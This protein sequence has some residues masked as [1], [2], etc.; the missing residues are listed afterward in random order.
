MLNN[1]EQ[2]L[3]KE[4][5]YSEHTCRAYIKDIEQFF[6]FAQIV[7]ENSSDLKEVNQ[8]LARSWVVFLLKNKVTPKSV[9]RKLSSN[10]MFYKFLMTHEL[11]VNNPFSSVQGPKVAKRL[12]EFV[13]KKE[14]TAEKMDHL[15]SG[16]AFGFRDR[17]LFEILYQTGIR[18]SEL[19]NLKE[20]DF[21][22]LSIR[23]VGKRN[24]E[25]VVA[26]GHGLQN[27]LNAL[28]ALKDDLGCNHDY[29]FFTDSLKKMYPKFVYRKI[30]YYLSQV[31][32]MNQKSPHIMRHTFATHLL[33]EGVSIEVLKEILGH[34]NLA[35]TQVYT[36]N[37]FE[38]INS[39]YKSAHPRGHK[40]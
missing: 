16:D 10:R 36:H 40:N 12:P 25:R 23:V 9:N 2:Y 29:L 14:I 38:Q 17:I 22:E 27:D 15:F 1:F 8:S 33:N 37:S 34:A 39:I 18:L 35:A 21:S 19:I 30:N 31:T 3:T 7:P 32:G 5:R 28:I 26:I 24:K 6:D 11:V 20:S 4:K 13:Q